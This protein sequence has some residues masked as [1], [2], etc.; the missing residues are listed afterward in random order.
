MLKFRKGGVLAIFR[1]RKVA[2]KSTALENFQYLAH[3]LISW[4][5]EVVRLH[6]VSKGWEEVKCKTKSGEH[7]SL[8]NNILHNDNTLNHITLEKRN[9]IDQTVKLMKA[10][11]SSEHSPKSCLSMRLLITL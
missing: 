6:C 5:V 7:T 10:R 11:L 1:H 3:T 8:I 2:E 4:L 9:Y